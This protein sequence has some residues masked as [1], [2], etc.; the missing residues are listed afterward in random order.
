[1]LA[2]TVMMSQP[3]CQMLMRYI[4]PDLAMQSRVWMGMCIITGTAPVLPTHLE[5]RLPHK[6]RLLSTEDISV[7]S[8]GVSCSSRHLSSIAQLNNKSSLHQPR[9]HTERKV[10]LSKQLIERKISYDL[11]QHP[12]QTWSTNK[13]KPRK[14]TL[15]SEK[16]MIQTTLG[17]QKGPRTVDQF[18]KVW[19]HYPETIIPDET[20]QIL[21]NNPR[22]LKLGKSIIS[23]T[24]SF[25]LIK[26]LGVGVICI[27]EASCQI[28]Y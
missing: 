22:G 19:G 23:T 26:Q 8:S 20:L 13:D 18:Q 5:S 25:S 16:N 27:P 4:N 24:H 9:N 21:L 6:H 3:H 10:N 2:L 11:K 15:R 1:M 12:Q 17:I 28:V 7:I 14:E